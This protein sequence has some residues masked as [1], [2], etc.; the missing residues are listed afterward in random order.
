MVNHNSKKANADYQNAHILWFFSVAVLFIAVLNIFLLAIPVLLISLFLRVLGV[1]VYLS[2]NDKNTN[3]SDL[4]RRALKMQ[5]KSRF[6]WIIALLCLLICIAL[7]LDSSGNPYAGAAL[8]FLCGI[9]G[10][11]AM[12]SAISTTIIKQNI[13]K[14]HHFPKHLKSTPAKRKKTKEYYDD[15]I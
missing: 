13:I 6:Y 2:G 8:W 4:R 3:R 7:F 14:R 1:V 11:M 12:I 10:V 9:L 5:N 15:S